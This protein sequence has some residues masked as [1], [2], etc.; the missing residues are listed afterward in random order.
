M[1]PIISPDGFTNLINLG[2]VTGT[3]PRFC[4]PW[5]ATGLDLV[6]DSFLRKRDLWI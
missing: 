5:D 3:S 6:D 2:L 4:F 1:C